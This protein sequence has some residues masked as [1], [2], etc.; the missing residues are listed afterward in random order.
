MDDKSSVCYLFLLNNISTDE[1]IGLIFMY[2][3]LRSD[4]EAMSVFIIPQ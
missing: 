4:H 3:Y 1:K 2:R